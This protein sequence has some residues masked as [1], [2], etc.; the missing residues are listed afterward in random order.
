MSEIALDGVKKYMDTTLV[1][2]NITFLITE[3]EKVGIV[4]GNGCGKT[5]ILKLIAGLLKLNHCA[6]YPYA[7]VPPGYDEGWVKI[8]KDT[9]V[10]YLEQIPQYA[11]NMKVIDV[12][13]QSFEEIHMV[14]KEMHLLEKSM[15]EL[16]GKELEKTLNRYSELLQL[17][18]FKGGYEIDE[19]LN[20]ICT[21]LKFDENFLNQDFNL[22]SGGEKT[23][24]ILG[25]HLIDTPDVLLLDEPTNH[26]D[27]DSVEW[28]EGYI[29]NYKGIVIVVSH[30][31]Y[32]LDHAVTKIIEVENKVCET[33][34]GNYSDFVR[35]KEENLQIQ[36]NNYKE[37]SKKINHMEQSIKELRE[38]AMKADNKK[39]FKRAASMQIKLD[40]LERI[41]KPVAQHQSMRLNLK[42]SERS[43]KIVIKATGLSKSFEK[44]NIL[45][46]AELLIQYGERVALI[47]PNGCGKTTFLKML[48]GELTSDRGEVS[49]GA[50]VRMAYLPQNLTFEDEELTVLDYFREDISILEG[51]AREHLAKFMFYGGNVFKKIKLLS[52]GE[53]VRLKLSKLLYHDVN[54]LI[55]DEPT[56]HLDT[57]SIESI[58]EALY[59]F[60][61]TIFFISHD[62]YFINK[63]SERVIVIEDCGFKSYLGNYDYYKNEKEK[64]ANLI[65]SES[66]SESFLKKSNKNEVKGKKNTSTTENVTQKDKK[67]KSHHSA[68]NQTNKSEKK[69]FQQA[70]VEERVKA[71]ESEIRELEACMEVSGTDYEELNRLFSR[72]E[73]LSKELDQLLEE[74]VTT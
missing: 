23:T 3:G 32:F 26:L 10:A 66:Q 59:G 52:G 73:A 4:G 60:K 8:S 70:K 53:K 30:D 1:L 15:Q 47:G 57:A 55:L 7:P 13:N 41:E 49:L 67:P 48:L 2:K 68:S 56:N 27:M 74:W 11:D 36:F 6:G 40:K 19:K 39:F 31:R 12:L 43:G 20:K 69:A 9:T 5:T 17:Y 54:L 64:L 42:T 38:W 62:R 29:K 21:G 58:E 37:Q 46:N 72:K 34:F 16:E 25:K 33:Y 63:I 45:H 18:E 24:V 14:E 28:L 50:N 65:D 44:K 71:I 51:K 61:G 35:Q 22:L